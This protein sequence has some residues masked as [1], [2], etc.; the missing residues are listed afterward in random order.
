MGLSST[1]KRVNSG[2][3]SAKSHKSL[4]RKHSGQGK[5]VLTEAND[6]FSRY[7]NRNVNLKSAMIINETKK[8]I[9]KESSGPREALLASKRGEGNTE[10]LPA[11][12]S[13]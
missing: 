13:P 2:T 3:S 12:R 9:T 10:T 6:Y 4:N 5:K 11:F 8:E 7:I 1:H